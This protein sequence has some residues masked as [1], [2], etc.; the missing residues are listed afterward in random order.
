MPC[1]CLRLRSFR[2]SP[3]VNPEWEWFIELRATAELPR[4][5]HVTRNPVSSTLGSSEPCSKLTM[6]LRP[7][8]Q[9]G[10][11]PARMLAWA[12]ARNRVIPFCSCSCPHQAMRQ[13]STFIHSKPT[14]CDQWDNAARAWHRLGA[15]LQWWLRPATEL[16]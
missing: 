2:S 12:V 1:G 7:R 16:M 5:R 11:I 4:L 10:R 6:T 15:L 3:A 13:Y 8:P 9:P 14:T